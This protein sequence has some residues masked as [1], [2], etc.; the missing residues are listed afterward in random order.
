MQTYSS[1]V[2]LAF[3]THAGIRW[4]ASSYMYGYLEL[5]RKGGCRQPVGGKDVKSVEA[6]NVDHLFLHNH[7]TVSEDDSIVI[8]PKLF[9]GYNETAVNYWTP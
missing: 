5:R 1:I 6:P 3:D 2:R 7:R 8:S 9:A 4:S